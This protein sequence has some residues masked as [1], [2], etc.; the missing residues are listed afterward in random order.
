MAEQGHFHTIAPTENTSAA[1]LDAE[2]SLTRTPIILVVEDD[3]HLMDGIREI[4]ELD[5]YRVLT[6]SSGLEALEV[7]Q[8]LEREPDLIVSDIMMP[9]MDGYQFFEE[10]RKIDAWLTVPFIFLTAKGEKADIRLG[11]S[12]GVDDYVTKPFSAED[13]LVAVSSKLARLNQYKSVFSSHVGDMKRRILTIL[14]HEFRTPLTYVVAYADM[15]KRDSDDMSLDELRVFLKGINSGADR[16]RRLVEN[17][18]LLVEIETGEMSLTFAWRKQPIDDLNALIAQGLRACEEILDENKHVADVTVAE[19]LSV[20]EGDKEYLSSA[21]AR[22]VENASKF[23]DNK[24]HSVIRVEAGLDEQG[25]VVIRVIDEGRGIAADELHQIFDPFY[26]IN[27]EQNEDQGAGSG[28][29][30]VR[31]IANVHGAEIAVYS[32]E[33]EGSTFSLHIPAQ[34]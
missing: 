16:L 18:I 20:I 15:V 3:L 32:V 11:K 21:I 17:F 22:L 2:P 9:K 26:Q 33:G 34:A 23:T 10:V 27:R 14:N 6:A 29:A 19:N 4:L 30:I 24:P 8:S 5:N 25:R 12:M 13:L 28:L 1:V 7:L 31:G